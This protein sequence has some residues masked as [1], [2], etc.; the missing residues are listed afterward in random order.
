MARRGTSRVYVEYRGPFFTGRIPPIVRE[1][2][3]TAV[4]KVTEMTWAE[5]HSQMDS[6]FRH[7][8]GYFESRMV[9]VPV[10]SLRRVIEDPVI[11]GNWLE[12]TSKRNEGNRF[13]GYKIWRRTRQKMQKLA[14][15]IAQ[16]SLDLFIGRMN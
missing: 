7:P 10:T 15:P 9:E 11:Y 13:K 5:L 14:K 2:L 8:T 6:K 3:A 1:W 4:A 12:G 16:E